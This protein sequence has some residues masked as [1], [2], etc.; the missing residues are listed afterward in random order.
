MAP[1]KPAPSADKPKQVKVVPLTRQV[2]V[3]R[4]SPDGKIL[5]AGGLDGVVHRFDASTDAFAELP[6][7]TGHNGWVQALAFHPD[8]KRLFSGD[9]WGRLCCWP[10]TEAN[11]KSLWDLPQAHDV[12]LRQ[13]AVSPDGGTIATCAADGSVRLWAADGGAKKGEFLHTSDVLALAYAPD[14]K[15]LVTGD[16]AGTVRQI[17]LATGKVTRTLDAKVLTHLDRM[18]D[19][20]G[21][22]SLAFDREGKTLAVAGGQPTTGGFVQ[23]SAT[24]LLFDWAPGTLAHTLKTAGTNDVY[25]HDVHFHPA[26]YVM[27]VSSGQ[28]GVGKLYFQKPGEPQPFFTAPLA[29]CHS[30]AVHPSLTK[31][32]VAATNT[33]SSGNGRNLNANKEYPGNFSPLHVFELPKG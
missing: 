22:R 15:S 26:G 18:Q 23:G 32:V 7:L 33:G 4:F 10:V 1:P 27:A 21:V 9:S 3:L 19:V 11:P 29:N 16:L 13:L 17:D 20:G 25:A 24:V 31:V 6:P 5:A 12:W 8:G 28:P 2:G 30:L 14:G